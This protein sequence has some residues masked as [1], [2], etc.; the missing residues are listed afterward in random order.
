MASVSRGFDE[1]EDQ[2]AA[3][4]I[5]ATQSCR[6]EL[7][8]RLGELLYLSCDLA[9]SLYRVFCWRE[10]AKGW[11]RLLVFLVWMVGSFEGWSGFES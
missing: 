5:V 3:R 1:A 4:A 10:L 9:C 2:G 6:G 8:A 11:E 7:G